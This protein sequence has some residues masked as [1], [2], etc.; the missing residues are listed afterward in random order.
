M[1]IS[2]WSIKN[3]IPAVMLFLLLTL[4]GLTSFVAL[5]VQDIPDMDLPAVTIL[6]SLPGAS[7]AQLETDV[8]RKLENAIAT[9]QGLKHITTKI[10]DGSV[11]FIAE[12]RLEKSVQDAVN[13]VRS[14][15][16]MIRSDLPATMRDPIINKLDIGGGTILA[17]SVNSKNADD[18]TLSS[19]VDD[20][21]SKRVLTIN[22]VGSVSRVG[23][24]DRE[25]RVALDPFKLRALGITVAD[26]SNRLQR[27]LTE[28]SGGK[29]DVGGG[30]QAIRTLT[31]IKSVDQLRALE[32]TLPNGQR[33]RLGEVASVEDTVAEVHSAA[34]LNGKPVVG[35]EISASKGGDQ[36]AVAKEVRAALDELHTL[37]P[38]MRFTETFNLV[39]PVQ[40]AFDGSMEMLYDGALLA[41]LVVWFFLKDFRATLISAFAL[42]LSAIPAFLGMYYFGF[43]LNVITLLALSL[44]IG[45]LVDDA[46][47]EVENIM[48]HLRKGIPPLEAARE[49]STEIGM[50][51]V[52]TTLA[53]VAVFLPTAF[54]GGTAGLFFRQFGITA[55]LAIL[56]SLA[57]ARMITPMMAAYLLKIT[58]EHEQTEGPVKKAYLRSVVWCLK[59]RL[60]TISA[61]SLFFI[62]SLALVSL[63]PAELMPPDDDPQT[64]V[65]VELP[66]GSTLAQTR[67]AAEAARKLVAGIPYVESI[68][69]TIGGGSA[70][71][72]PAAVQ[73]A[74]GVNKATLT[75]L[76]TA[77]N[78]PVIKS[79]IEK[80]IVK[81]LAALPGVRTKVGLGGGGDK[82][83][84]EL[85][86]DNPEALASA[87]DTAIKAIRTIPGFGTITSSAALV[88]PEITVR[89]NF[90]KAAE[91]GVATED[92]AETLRI[93]T[94]GDY[95][96]TAPKLNL[97][98][99]QIPVSIKLTAEARQDLS[100]L[101]QLSVP[102]SKPEIGTVTI[103]EIAEF[104]FS[105]GQS[106]IDRYD[107]SRNI[108]LE[109]QLVGLSLGE[110]AQTV[111][112][113]PSIR[114][115]PAGIKQ[116]GVG[117]AE[118][119]KE[120]FDSFG[121]A[122]VAG[123]LC[124]YCVLVLL[125]KDFLQPITILAALPLSFGGGFVALLLTGKSLS[126]P[127][128]IGLIMLMGIATKNS[129]L[130]VEY[131]IA[132]RHEPGNDRASALLDACRKRVR[133]I[134][135]TTIAMAAGMLPIAMGTG[136]ADSPFRSPMAIAVIGGLAT[137]TFL[138]LFVIPVVYTY[139]DDFEGFLRRLFRKRKP[140]KES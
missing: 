33:I 44:V 22:G 98:Q 103:G 71:N 96:A 123:I 72:N 11:S 37:Y 135:M 84:L 27:V 58:S 24:A 76:L 137:S 35:F 60:L 57:V 94:V 110:A 45:I 23:G 81:A 28:N 59:H 131:A 14:A 107:R 89:P 116:V 2:A 119:M 53:L 34:Y 99:R 127:S 63:L 3:P 65:S 49:A 4:G 30:E 120:L 19:F 43:S 111:S 36:I 109:I 112:K 21:V 68:Y 82:Y 92:I 31:D 69:T 129:I 1:N 79:V 52:A 64:Q 38:E 41:V 132:A 108:N 67:D 133:P 97:A 32:L 85:S 48:R 101:E 17:Y 8:A 90:A 134:I 12:F 51:V 113:L 91:M 15:V 86:G 62:G 105:G 87:A 10:Q 126:M 16:A 18:E 83:V 46:I 138:S 115:L 88:K 20:V 106:T 124:I 56:A 7:P 73:G 136:T 39:A 77:K 100:L 140:I 13:D 29:S 130:L 26:I 54:M 93:S 125:F 9:I 66:P 40:E 75:V 50:A 47:V 74:E 95:E 42:P 78:R 128:L 122:M 25:A 114:N 139:V 80:N 117:D 61:A 118:E 55:T 102:S 6:C 121:I 5:N 104:E 70:G